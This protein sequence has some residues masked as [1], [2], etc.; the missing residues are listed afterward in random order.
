M[1]DSTASVSCYVIGISRPAVKLTLEFS[2]G[3]L[4]KSNLELFNY[5]QLSSGI[6]M[7]YVPCFT[8]LYSDFSALTLLVGHQEGHPAC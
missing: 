8:F 2:T 5:V 7:F 4:N 1:A 6:C 3:D